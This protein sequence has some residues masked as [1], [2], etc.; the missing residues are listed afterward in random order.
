MDEGRELDALIAEKIMGWTEVTNK[1]HADGSWSGVR[2][3]WQSPVVDDVPHYSTKIKSAWKVVEKMRSNYE[4]DLSDH[5]LFWTARFTKMKD[6]IPLVT[7]APT[8]AH[9]I[10]L[11]ALKV[12]EGG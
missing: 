10:C 3:D 9:A 1:R 11:A 12:I 4:L 6:T 5:I 2:H 8:A 7:E